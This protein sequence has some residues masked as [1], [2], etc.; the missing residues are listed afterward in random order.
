MSAL[1]C[2]PKELLQSVLQQCDLGT[3]LA[4]ARCSSIIFAAASCKHVFAFLPPVRVDSR[5]PDLHTKL[6]ASL[7]HFADLELA[8]HS[9]RPPV[10]FEL[11]Q[12]LDE[13]EDKLEEFFRSETSTEEEFKAAE[14]EVKRLRQLRH[15][16]D[17]PPSEDDAHKLSTLPH[18]RAL[19][20]SA[21]EHIPQR[22]LLPFFPNIIA[23][24]LN[25]VSALFGPEA[26]AAGEWLPELLLRMATLRSLTFVAGAPQAATPLLRHIGNMRSLTTLDVGALHYVGNSE[27]LLAALRTRHEVRTL[28]LMSATPKLLRSLDEPF[29]ESITTLTLSQPYLYEMDT[30]PNLLRWPL[31]LRLLRL[32][33]LAHM[34]AVLAHLALTAPSSLVTLVIELGTHALTK[35]EDVHDFLVSTPSAHA[36]EQLLQRQTQLALNIQPV[37]TGTSGG[38]T[39]TWQQALSLLLDLL[40]AACPQRVHIQPLRLR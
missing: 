10:D 39:R 28:R 33:E 34:D 17:P 31:A 40:L 2:L 20:V 24:K 19:D 11:L 25:A 18:L 38:A 22:L 13:A 9:V 35:P 15:A 23:L 27:L 1:D 8:W 4:L 29:M 3:L 37:D 12:R 26:E 30:I 7:L 36:M 6:S 14:A 16:P 21:L 32:Q 5:V